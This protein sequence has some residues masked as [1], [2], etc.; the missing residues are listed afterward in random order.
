MTSTLLLQLHDLDGYATGESLVAAVASAGR[1]PAARVGARSSRRPSEVG[2]VLT[3]G[4]VHRSASSGNTL[5]RVQRRHERL[6]RVAQVHEV[7]EPDVS[8]EKHRNKALTL[9]ACTRRARS[10]GSML[11]G[12][13]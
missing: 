13:R 10:G 1:D 5:A 8:F 4:A 7:A 3:R 12:S 11:R 2:R 6:S 9:H